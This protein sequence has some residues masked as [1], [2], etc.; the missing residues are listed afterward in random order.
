[1]TDSSESA[2]QSSTWWKGLIQRLPVNRPSNEVIWSEFELLVDGGNLKVSK[3]LLAED[4]A[5]FLEIV[6]QVRVLYHH[7]PPPRERW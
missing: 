5:R 4:Q 1:M 6:D 7:G 3:E 2:H